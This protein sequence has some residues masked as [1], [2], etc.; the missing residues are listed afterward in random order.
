M[1]SGYDPPRAAPN[2]AVCRIHHWRRGHRL[3]RRP[4]SRER[5]H[6]LCGAWVESAAL[7]CLLS[8][9]PW[10]TVENWRQVVDRSRQMWTSARLLVLKIHKFRQ[11]WTKTARYVLDVHV[12]RHQRHPPPV[13]C[14]RLGLSSLY[15]TPYSGTKQDR[16]VR[17]FWNGGISFLEIAQYDPPQGCQDTAAKGQACGTGP[18]GGFV[19]PVDANERI[20]D[21]R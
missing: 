11:M 16:R 1:P 21:N 14:P 3:H 12:F 10:T 2:E 15:S 7:C 5:V 20:D 8:R 6:R 18:W 17:I 13:R 19:E 4:E 9:S